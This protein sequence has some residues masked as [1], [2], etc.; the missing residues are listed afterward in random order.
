MRHKLRSYTIIFF[1]LSAV[2][3]AQNNQPWTGYVQVRYAD[4]FEQTKTFLIRRLKLWSYQ[5]TPFDEHLF[6]KVQAIFRY[7]VSGALILQDA[8]AEY[9]TSTW[10]LR[11][12]QETPDFSLQRSQPDFSLF[13]IERGNI[14]NALI[15]ASESLARDIGIQFHISPENFPWSGSFGLFNG[16][17]ANVKEN[18]DQW[19]LLTTRHTVKFKIRA[20][21][22]FETG[23]SLSFRET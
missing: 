18:E 8:F 14:I 7:P 21:S 13:F 3:F 12:G 17:G 5:Q 6:Y 11:V 15:P 16:N 22:H 1:V 4:N 2:V 19:F 9:R 20:S 23:V 10:W